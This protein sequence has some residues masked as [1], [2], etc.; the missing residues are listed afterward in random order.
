MCVHFSKGPRESKHTFTTNSEDV[1]P[2]ILEKHHSFIH[3]QI[4]REKGEKQLEMDD[5]PVFIKLYILI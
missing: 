3:P 2:F 1:Y 5:S 4:H